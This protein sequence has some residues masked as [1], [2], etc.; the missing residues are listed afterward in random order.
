MKLILLSA[1]SLASEIASQSD[2]GKGELLVYLVIFLVLIFT[3]ITY[4]V[5]RKQK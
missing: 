2:K 3:S 1:I 5:M 4:F